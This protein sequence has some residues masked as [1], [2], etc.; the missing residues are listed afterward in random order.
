M[1]RA[2]QQ[3]KTEAAAHAAA[4]GADQASDTT[5]KEP[6]ADSQLAAAGKKALSA[7]QRKPAHRMQGE[8]AEAA[9]AVQAAEEAA[10]T[11]ALPDLASDQLGE[12]NEVVDSDQLQLLGLVGQQSGSATPLS[13]TQSMGARLG[14]ML[15]NAFSPSRQ[16]S[17]V[18]LDVDSP[19]EAQDADKPPEQE[20]SGTARRALPRDA[21]LGQRLGSILTGGLSIP[22][23]SSYTSLSGDDDDDDVHSEAKAADTSDSGKQ[24]MLGAGHRSSPR[25]A[26]LGQRLGSLLAGALSSPRQAIYSSVNGDDDVDSFEIS[27]K[28]IRSHVSFSK[29]LSRLHDVEGSER[30]LSR[31]LS[32][33][34]RY[35]SLTLSRD[36]S[37]SLPAGDS[38]A[39]PAAEHEPSV[40]VSPGRR[41]ALPRDASY[42]PEWV[43]RSH[44]QTPRGN[45]S[46]SASPRCR[47]GTSVSSA[48]TASD[49][50]V[51]APM[52]T[53]VD[54][55]QATPRGPTPQHAEEEASQSD[56]EP[57]VPILMAPPHLRRQQQDSPKA[58][59][60][61]PR[62]KRPLTFAPDPLSLSLVHTPSMNPQL[63]LS[64]IAPV[65]TPKGQ[66]LF[67][68]WHQKSE[69][70]APAATDVQAPSP[71]PAVP[72]A[73]ASEA[74]SSP[75]THA[76]QPG[77]AQ[78]ASPS[79]TQQAES[80]ARRENA[81]QIDAAGPTQLK[82]Q[83]ASSEAVPQLPQMPRHESQQH[84]LRAASSV[85]AL[86]AAACVPSANADGSASLQPGSVSAAFVAELQSATRLVHKQSLQQEALLEGI[87]QALS[88]L[89]EQRL[90]VQ[91]PQAATVMGNDK[92]VSSGGEWLLLVHPEV[93]TASA[94]P[95]LLG[96]DGCMCVVYSCAHPW[97]SQLAAHASACSYN[98]QL[99]ARI[100]KLVF[101]HCLNGHNICWG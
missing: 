43:T 3:A 7:V 32:L 25:D 54:W 77:N 92:V 17:Y 20:R 48:S 57:A 71:A 64:P 47:L 37:Y 41:R 13:K 1:R 61:L 58:V 6:L 18:P 19:P 15:K 14:S 9:A 86:T 51:D 70:R 45:G 4:K 90:L 67:D 94:R 74:H 63:D 88:Q 89:S 10:G 97:A 46:G 84:D 82:H 96:P 101:K 56:L 28:E 12:Q 65:A 76:D 62:A 23:Q 5:D 55:P 79:T 44:G 49:P 53:W 59:L 75:A 81:K 42:L 50:D 39:G 27:G 24:A 33:R 22:R 26:S 91:N 21:S 66:R 36:P 99:V 83:P 11:D 35:G 52:P 34:E 16:S 95:I 78:L 8:E 87:E 38:H 98:T 100:K 85:S 40:L 31:Q 60:S 69:Q 73:T 68:F 80:A 29:Q 2:V 72:T 30:V 93:N